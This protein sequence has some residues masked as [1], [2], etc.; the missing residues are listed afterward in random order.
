[1][2]LNTTFYSV[3]TFIMLFSACHVSY[4]QRAGTTVE[5]NEDAHRINSL[6]EAGQWE[7]G[8]K[9]AEDGLRKSPRDSDYRMLLGKYYIYK[10]DWDKARY[11]LVKSIEYNNTNVEAKH[12]LVTVETE[13]KRYSSA[14][15]YINEL[16]EV[17]PYWKGLWRKK[18]ELYRIQGNDVE[19][20]RLVKRINQVYPEDTELQELKAYTAEVRATSKSKEG[21]LS[22]AIATNKQIVEERPENFNSYVAVVDDYIKAGDYNNALVYTERGLNKFPANNV[23]VSKKIAILEHQNRYPEILS[24][25]ENQM[26][27]GG[28]MNYIRNQHSYFLLESARYAKDN[29]PATL[30]GKIFASNPGNKE[31]FDYL[32]NRLIG[33]QQYEEAIS[34][35]QKHR[36]RVGNNKDLDMKELMAYRRLGDASK[37]STLTRQYFQKYPNDEDLKTNY[38][39]YLL[40]DA[41]AGIQ[42][43]RY[44]DAVRDYRE[45]MLY[46]DQEMIETARTGLYTA[47]AADNRIDDAM[48]ALDDILFDDPKNTTLLLKKADLFYKQRK[49]SNAFNTYEQVLTAVLPHER[50]RYKDGYQEYMVPLIRDLNNAYKFHESMEFVRRWLTVD[51]RNQQALLYAINLSYQLKEYDQMLAYAKD[52]ESYYPDDVQYKV[53]L[54]E[55]MNTG[56]ATGGVL[57]LADSWT[58]LRQQIMH[59]AHHAP[60]VRTFTA[61]SED[62]A[63]Q[64]LKEKNGQQALEVLNTAILYNDTS[65]NLL[66]MKG[67]AYENLKVYDSAYY[68]QRYYTPS[69][70]EVD[71][72]KQHLNYLVQKG[73]K[74]HIG[75]YHLRARFGDYYG[76]TTI[77]TAEYTRTVDNGSWTGRVNYAGR[78]TG[79]GV[80][81]Q[82]EW[83]RTWTPEW[84]SRVDFGLSNKFFAKVAANGTLYHQFLPTWEAEAGLGYRKLYTNE[85]ILLLP[86]GATKYLEDFRLHGKLT[87]FL[88]EGNYLYSVYLSGQYYMSSPRNYLIAMSSIGNSPDI[89][90]LNNQLANSFSVFNAMVGAGFGRTITR[91][92]SAS[93]LGQW[94]NFQTDPVSPISN[95]TFRNLYNLY[96]QLHVSF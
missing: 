47:Y 26:R 43:G 95:T 27:V 94:Y 21:K 36:A 37:I 5:R 50:E 9:Q 17:N 41:K 83:Y 53:K 1:M 91:N 4:G 46:G 44:Q 40:Q 79:K 12:M 45:I 90:L 63:T 23:L 22:E 96:L 8:K 92:V 56:K 10:K 54:A 2:T 49:F 19:A 52:A 76:I 48:I 32:F 14:I 78:E 73:H 84:S 16:L 60:L 35:L 51:P 28:D 86:L 18:I 93:V 89:D 77:S 31:A 57:V 13:T 69:L 15:C 64:L 42:D 85:G 33:D 55:A 70:L 39:T 58:L 3:F 87:N 34:T 6:Y 7:E 24:F 72:F 75:L 65:K 38:V 88:V 30:Y 66:Y 67:L 11:E 71:D 61:T 20:D 62:Y 74:N 59:N 81:G 25:L 80:Q 82:V 68:Y 29:D